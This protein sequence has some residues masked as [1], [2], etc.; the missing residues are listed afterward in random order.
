MGKIVGTGIVVAFCL[1]AVSLAGLILRKLFPHHRKRGA[2]RAAPPLGRTAASPPPLPS[3]SSS[4]AH[5]LFEARSH[6]LSEAEQKFFGVLQPLVGSACN[7][8][9]KVRLADL[10]DVRPGRGQQAAFN[11]IQSKHIDFVLTDPATSRILCAIELDDSSHLRPDRIER[12][13]FI[14][15][16]F[17]RNHLPLLRVPCMWTY[18]TPAL[19]DALAAVG[20]PVIRAA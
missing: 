14:D 9:S 19:R 11:K 1:I 17:G 2:R 5:H 4:T 15:D 20:V 8:S 13:E 12:D 10:F 18:N 7:V 3:T 16:L 6:L